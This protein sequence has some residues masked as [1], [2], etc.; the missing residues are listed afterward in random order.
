MRLDVRLRPAHPS[1]FD[2]V[3][4]GGL[5]AEWCPRLYAGHTNANDVVLREMFLCPPAIVAAEGFPAQFAGL[6]VYYGAAVQELCLVAVA[7]APTG[8]GGVPRV[9]KGGTTYALYLVE[10]GDSNASPVR[11]RTSTGVKSVRKKT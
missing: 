11:I 9:S 6:R 2:V 10:T 8:M 1:P 3:L 5:Q 7:D 4:E